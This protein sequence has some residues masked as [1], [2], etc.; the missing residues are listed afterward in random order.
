MKRCYFVRHGES[1]SNVA[2]TLV[3]PTSP[4]SA[5]GERQSQFLAERFT[6]LPLDLIVASPYARTRQTAEIFN[7]VLKKPFVFSE[8]ITERRF[9]SEMTKLVIDDP[10][11]VAINDERV[12]HQYELH[13]RYS[14]EETTEELWARAKKALAFLTARPEEHVAVITHAGFMKVLIAVMLHGDA[15]TRQEY[16][17]LFSFLGLAANTGITICEWDSSAAPQEWL[18]VTWNDHAHLGEVDKP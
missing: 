13:Y 7:T 5:R 9:P 15:L 3:G 12:T 11:R 16:V 8:L 1:E 4:L 2:R 17:R 6:T 14:D 18:L 10:K